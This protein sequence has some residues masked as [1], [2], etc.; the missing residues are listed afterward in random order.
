MEN[1]F[2]SIVEAANSILILLPENPSF[3]EVA[4]GLGL[5]LA[6]RDK[7][8]ATI[9]CTTPMVVEFN[10]LVGVNKITS[11]LGNKNLTIKFADYKAND[12]ERVSYDIE[13]GQFRLSVIP[14]PGLPSPKKEQ[15]ELSYSGISGDTVILIGGKADSEFSALNSKDL[16]GSKLVHV[17]VR[18]LA[19]TDKALMS[20]AR[21]ASSLSEIIYSLL[22]E[23]EL[24]V[25]ADIATNLVAGIEDGSQ[26]FKGTDVTAET[27]EVMAHLLKAGGKRTSSQ[28]V[29]REFFPAG[30]IPGVPLEATENKEKPPKNWLEQPKIYK[31]TSIS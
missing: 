18:A 22:N 5:Y 4:A 30:S 19:A 8:D 23:S 17:G 9:S 12:I 29:S 27:F 16:L 10:R 20:F 1:S 13:N 31:G 24:T 14:K 6:L 3:D 7:K 21:P 15:V 2:K 25:D 11:E 28:P 26:A